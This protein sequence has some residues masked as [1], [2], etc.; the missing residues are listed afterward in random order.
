MVDKNKTTFLPP[1]DVNKQKHNLKK[2]TKTYHQHAS[3]DSGVF[4]V[5]A[6]GTM[7]DV[8][9]HI[10]TRTIRSRRFREKHATPYLPQL[11]RGL[12]APPRESYPHIDRERASSCNSRASRGKER[13][14]LGGFV[15]SWA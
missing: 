9:F 15:C 8:F 12:H 10:S 6:G 5:L 1:Q 13:N 14:V 11:Y 3:M 7:R 2:R 4:V